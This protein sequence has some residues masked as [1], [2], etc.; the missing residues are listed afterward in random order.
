MRRCVYSVKYNCYCAGA[1]EINWKTMIDLCWQRL[2]LR[3]YDRVLDVV[4]QRGP[5]LTR[6]TTLGTYTNAVKPGCDRIVIYTYRRKM[7]TVLATIAHE[8]GHAEHYHCVQG[9]DQWPEKQMEGYA[10]GI[11]TLM[12]G[13]YNDFIERE[14]ASLCT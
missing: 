13:V 1:I 11:E 3:G 5:S 14:Y 9:G 7:P 2:Q 8:F 6:N 4:F 12:L 10:Q